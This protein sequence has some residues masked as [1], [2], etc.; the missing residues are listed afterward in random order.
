M[1]LSDL[2]VH[3]VHSIIHQSFDCRERVSEG[4]VPPALNGDGTLAVGDI[5]CTWSELPGYLPSFQ[6]HVY[7]GYT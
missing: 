5:V 3:P 2:V 4:T 7:I 1:R 6:P